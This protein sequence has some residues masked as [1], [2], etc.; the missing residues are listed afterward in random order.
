MGTVPAHTQTEKGQEWCY[1]NFGAKQ[2]H[3][4]VSMILPKKHKGQRS[5][6]L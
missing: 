2:A 4:V 6:T 5:K 1:L 3:S